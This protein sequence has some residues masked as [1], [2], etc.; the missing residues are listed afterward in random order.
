MADEE[1]KADAPAGDPQPLAAA[2]GASTGSHGSKENIAG[3]RSNLA[4]SKSNLAG[5]K[6]NLAGSKS[7]LAGSRAASLR[8]LG[9]KAAPG[10]PPGGGGGGGGGGSGDGSVAPANAVV[11]ENTYKLKPDKK[12]QSGA[13][14]RIV[15]ESLAQHL[16]KVKYDFEK[17]PEL[18]KTIANDILASVK[19][20]E[21]DRYKLV[22]E[23]DI[24][25][26][27]GQGIK[28][29]SRAVWD[30]TTDSYASASFKNLVALGNKQLEPRLVIQL[31]RV[32]LGESAEPGPTPAE[33]PAELNWTQKYGSLAAS[34]VLFTSLSF[35]MLR[36]TSLQMQFE[37]ARAE[38][39]AELAAIRAETAALKRELAELT[40]SES[41]G[42]DSSQSAKPSSWWRWF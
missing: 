24:G 30:T 42:G 10:G 9:G 19:K 37:D 11:F 2:A 41:K 3:S 39:E 16:T 5:S 31:R 38:G 12:F 1:P 27:K 6:S 26:F 4:G 21:F 25:E 40:A 15:E 36:Y 23:V 8:N 13:V 28:I 34:F 7:N 35:G 14:K 18:C 29:A 22:V 20:L 17:V 32:F 33:E